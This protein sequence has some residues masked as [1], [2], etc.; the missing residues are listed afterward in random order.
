MEDL[1]YKLNHG[2]SVNDDLSK[3]LELTQQNL[4]NALEKQ[5]KTEELGR[6]AQDRASNEI[7][8]LN[9]QLEKE[10]NNFKQQLEST[11]NEKAR[12]LDNVRKLHDTELDKQESKR[13]AEMSAKN[14]ELKELTK[15]FENEGRRLDE[16]IAHKDRVNNSLTNDLNKERETLAATTKHYESEINDLLHQ[17]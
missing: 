8:S 12:E 1:D 10:R 17:K 11:L 9:K 7:T 16:I 15:T 2:S 13:M 6:I 4:K 5:A 3:K 14:L